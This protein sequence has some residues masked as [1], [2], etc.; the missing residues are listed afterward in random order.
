M[1][2]PQTADAAAS[3]TS[4]PDPWPLAIRAGMA[5]AEI[6]GISESSRDSDEFGALAA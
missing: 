1:D 5:I 4:A 6:G 2:M 3:T